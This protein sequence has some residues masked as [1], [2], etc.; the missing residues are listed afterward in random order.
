[1]RSRWRWPQA[2]WRSRTQNFLRKI[3]TRHV[4]A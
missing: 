3:M 1:V 2:A 4:L